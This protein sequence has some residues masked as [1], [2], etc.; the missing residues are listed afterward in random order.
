MSAP[1][2]HD[3]DHAEGVFLYAVQALPG[4]EA[5]T[6][7]SRI[8][9]CPECRRELDTLTVVVRSLVSWP[10]DVLRPP[11]SLWNRLAERVAAETGQ[12]PL[13]PASRTGTEPEWQ[14]VAPGISCKLLATDTEEN[15]VSMLVRLAPGAEYAAHRHVGIEECYMLEGVLIVDDEKFY[16]GD[17][18]RRDADSV[19]RRI[20]SET[21]CSCVL[22]TSLRDVIL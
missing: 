4:D 15:R 9:A 19:D 17:Y 2:T 18:R 12:P 20:W 22:I 16:P 21:G 1:G 10:T 11:A 14:E 8:A 13:R 3:D 6:V 5:S 7:E